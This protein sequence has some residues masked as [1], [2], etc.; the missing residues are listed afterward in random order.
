MRQEVIQEAVKG[1][2]PAVV[3][4]TAWVFGLTLNDW[5]AIGTLTYLALQGAFLLWRW[6]KEIKKGN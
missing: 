4:G 5:V 6:W 2:P 1:A 3:A